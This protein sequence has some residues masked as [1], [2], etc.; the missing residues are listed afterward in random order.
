VP[1][2][3]P[4]EDA[5]AKQGAIQSIAINAFPKHSHG[6]NRGTKE[7]K[8]KRRANQLSYLRAGKHALT[9]YYHVLVCQSKFAS[10]QRM[11]KS[12]NMAGSKVASAAL[13]I[14]NFVAELEMG[15]LTCSQSTPQ[16]MFSC[17]AAWE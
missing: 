16:A 7:W 11:P 13:E 15:T 1:E 17:S 2:Y 4:L 9:F 12:A 10:A 8:R 14:E 3:H 6:L 5:N